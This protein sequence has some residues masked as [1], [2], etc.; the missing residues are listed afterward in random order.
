M[1]VV[2]ILL[3]ALIGILVVALG[4]ACAALIL[5]RRR[6]ASTHLADPAD[7]SKR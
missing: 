7:P 2:E 1:S 4:V 5:A 6:A 3:V